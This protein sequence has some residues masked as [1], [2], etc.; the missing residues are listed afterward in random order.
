MFSRR[1]LAFR[2]RIRLALLRAVL[3][4]VG[5]DVFSTR[6]ICREAQQIQSTLRVRDEQRAEI[7]MLAQGL[8]LV[9][10]DSRE[11]YERVIMAFFQGRKSSTLLT[12]VE[13][14]QFLDILR[15]WTRA[16]AVAR[17]K[18]QRVA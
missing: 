14:R 13:H 18:A 10:R 12:D 11:D 3:N 7:H 2:D 4:C 5:F 17:D 8:G 9:R 16:A 1:L 6:R 15:A